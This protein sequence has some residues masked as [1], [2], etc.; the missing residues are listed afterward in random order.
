MLLLDN[1]WIFCSYK[2]SEDHSHKVLA[3]TKDMAFK[4]A[5]VDKRSKTISKGKIEIRI[6]SKNVTTL[7]L[8]LRPRQRGL[9][10]CGPR[11]SPKDTPH[12]PENVGKCEGMKPHTPKATPTLGDGV[13]IDSRIFRGRS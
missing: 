12:A 8:G 3:I 13:S 2:C 4:K 9:Q 5:P 10:S 1:N 7:A 11:G 6:M